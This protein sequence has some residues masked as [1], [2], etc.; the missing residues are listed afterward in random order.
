M[1][2]TKA[3]QREGQKRIKNSESKIRDKRER[4][5]TRLLQVHISPVIFALWPTAKQM[6]LLHS[7]HQ[8]LILQCYPPGKAVDK[9]PNPSEMSYLLYYASTRRVKLEKVIVYIQRKTI[10]D[11]SRRKAG[12]LQVTLSILSALITKCADNLNVFA[13]GVCSVIA[14]ILNVKDVALSKSALKTYGT[15]CSKLDGGL[16]SGDKDFISKFTEVSKALI[17]VDDPALVSTRSPDYLDWKM[18]SI[19]ACGHVSNCI[20]FN[21]KLAK[22]FTNLCIPFCLDIINDGFKAADL[23]AMLGNHDTEL[24]RKTLAVSAQP[25]RIR[26]TVTSGTVSSAAVAIANATDATTSSPGSKL[27]N[28]ADPNSETNT[29]T[30]A[31]VQEVAL[32]ALKS[33]FDTTLLSQI[34]ESTKVV[35]K[36]CYELK[37]NEWGS[38]LLE[39]CTTWV[40]VQLRFVLLTTLL[41]KLSLIL[42]QAT[43]IAPNYQVQLQFANYIMALLS[44]KVNMIGLLVSDVIQTLLFLQAKVVLKQSTFLDV[45]QVGGLLDVYSNC[46]CNLSTHVYYFDQVPDSIQE[47]LIMIDSTL[48]KA[49]ASRLNANASVATL[50]QSSS[51]DTS[52]A[53][54]TGTSSPIVNPD[55]DKVFLLVNTLL[56]DVSM[57]LNTLKNK[58]SSISRNHVQ[59]QHWEISLGLLSPE[60]SFNHF[61]SHVLSRDAITRIQMRYIQ[62]FRDFLSHEFYASDE[63]TLKDQPGALQ[64]GDNGAQ[65][66]LS[67]DNQYVSDSEN[68]VTRLLAHLDKFFRKT[69]FT[70]ETLGDALVGLI[71]QLLKDLSRSLGINFFKN[72]VPFFFHWVSLQSSHSTPSSA[73]PAPTPAESLTASNDNVVPSQVSSH[74][75]ALQYRTSVA[76]TIMHFLLSVIDDAYASSLDN[77]HYCIN[78]RFYHDLENEIYISQSSGSWALGTDEVKLTISTSDHEAGPLS[79]KAFHTL[80]NGNRWLSSWINLANGYDMN[81]ALKMP[82]RHRHEDDVPNQPDKDSSLHGMNGNSHRLRPVSMLSSDESDSRS[83]INSPTHNHLLEGLGLGTAGDITLIHSEIL[84]NGCHNNFSGFASAQVSRNG[85]NLHNTTGSISSDHSRFVPRVSDLKNIVVSRHPH[86]SMFGSSYVPTSAQSVLSRQLVQTDMKSILDGLGSDCESE[87]V[88]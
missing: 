75:A 56:S 52:N 61:E 50:G 33:F 44:S 59:L 84:H 14:A 76:Y 7:K 30:E 62:V 32:L 83:S 85:L 53:G 9:K 51:I 41:N 80:I 40:P 15:L 36:R 54:E 49:F 47:I 2:Q 39:L 35:V 71:V 12:N 37:K 22:Y 87:I 19:L 70:T 25:R 16:F 10:L 46:I 67:P 5:I 20:G 18:I 34:S 4:K 17:G 66:F 8:K 74:K 55:G 42:D 31:D 43:Q 24:A 58:A 6:G 72:F 26:L 65:S 29:L 60:D 57:I 45:T 82:R 86:T 69:V 79:K 64:Y 63:N 88:V 78:S 1:H 48:E 38:A 81:A 28:P 73:T 21:N 13:S 3:C 68:Y 77:P 11:V 23:V 27:S